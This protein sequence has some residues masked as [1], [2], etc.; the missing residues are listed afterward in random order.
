M[1][2]KFVS[3]DTFSFGVILQNYDFENVSS[4]NLVKFMI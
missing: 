3:Y 2:A 4:Q 1:K